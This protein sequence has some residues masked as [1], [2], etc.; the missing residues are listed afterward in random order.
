MSQIRIGAWQ[1]R[2]FNQ[3]GELANTVVIATWL[4]ALGKDSS[5]T[6]IESEAGVTELDFLLI[7]DA[8][9]AAIRQYQTQLVSLVRQLEQSDSG[10]LVLILGKSFEVVAE[11]I[12]GLR[13]E[14]IQRLSEFR[15]YD[16]DLGILRGYLNTKLKPVPIASQGRLL[17]SSLHGPVL[18]SSP[19]LRMHVV[20][21]MGVSAVSD[22]TM[23]NDFERYERQLGWI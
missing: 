23:G 7:G 13:L 15:E 14:A 22:A 1:P 11:P 6:P 8:G 3:N 5:F 2:Y 17:G 20:E 21:R 18:A 16:S 4:K 12:F 9:R 19:N 10:P